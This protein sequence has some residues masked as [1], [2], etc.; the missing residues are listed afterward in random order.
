M[1]LSESSKHYLDLPISGGKVTVDLSKDESC[2]VL[3]AHDHGVGSL[4]E[5]ERHE[6]NRI[7]A[8]LKDQIWP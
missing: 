2:V 8:K 4:D 3:M 6:L 7:I 1:T 5:S